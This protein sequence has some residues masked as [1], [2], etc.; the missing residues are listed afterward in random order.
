[1]RFSRPRCKP[2]TCSDA[3]CLVVVATLLSRVL[4]RGAV[5]VGRGFGTGWRIRFRNDADVVRG[6]GEITGFGG[7][8]G[9]CADPELVNARGGDG[10]AIDGDGKAQLVRRLP[11]GD[12][13]GSVDESCHV[14]PVF[15]VARRGKPASLQ[16]TEAAPLAT[17]PLDE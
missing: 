15:S 8:Q 5:G 10:S 11:S 14:G 9:L 13:P 2:V 17:Q 4:D 16:L 6:E 3:Q 12:A 7:G 1:E